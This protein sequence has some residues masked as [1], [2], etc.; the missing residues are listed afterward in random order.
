VPLR[1]L[2][3]SSLLILVSQE[4]W[5]PDTVHV[6][7]LV[8]RV[9]SLIMQAGFWK[10][11]NSNMK[12]SISCYNLEGTV[13]LQDFQFFGHLKIFTVLELEIFFNS[14]ISQLQFL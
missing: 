13:K 7:V 5:N 11:R 8:H 10:S 12:F 6:Q 3:I 2:S 9:L 4:V 14:D 1:S